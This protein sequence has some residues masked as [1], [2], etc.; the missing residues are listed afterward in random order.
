MRL[1][2]EVFAQPR[3]TTVAN[4]DDSEGTSKGKKHRSS[5]N[6]KYKMVYQSGWEET[7]RRCLEKG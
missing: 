2:V 3:H 5:N 1:H 7:R 6:T 4:G